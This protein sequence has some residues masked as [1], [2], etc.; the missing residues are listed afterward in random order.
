MR[1][2]VVT[3]IPGPRSRAL[4]RELRQHESRNVTFLDASWPVFWESA[5]GCQVWDAD[6]NRF[7]DFTSAFGVAG[8]G[9]RNP[10]VVAAMGEQ[11]NRLLHGMG[12]VH[13]TA[14][15]GELCRRL[16]ELTFER[17]QL[18]PGKVILS[19]SG[20]EAVESALK[21]ARLATGK[22][23]VLAF[24]NGYHGLGYGS[25]M[26]T[27]LS[28]F[29]G[30]F[31][32]QL[33]P[34]T[35]RI[36][37]G[38]TD[39]PDPGNIGVV[40]VEPIQGRGGKVLP[41]PGFLAAL[42]SWCDHHGA[43]LIFDEIYT[44]FHRTG[45]WFACEEDGV[46]PDLI[47]VGKAMSGG[48]PIS[49]CVGRAGIMDEWPESTGE[50]LHTST[51]LGNPVGCAMALKSL[52][53]LARPETLALVGKTSAVLANALAGLADLENVI[54]IRGRGVMWGVEL[55]RPGGPLLAELL[56][57]GLLFLA[58]GPR[59]NVLSFTPPFVMAEED[60]VFGVDRVRRLLTR[61]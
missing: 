61:S 47:C 15:K 57:E 22:P 35:T 44:G 38:S 59:G 45:S 20:F 54:A 8:L 19:N 53:I 1:P 5:E 11:A 2:E 25:L 34:V 37:Y 29:R 16:S 40:L 28:K 58:D 18:G 49:A 26:G 30:P 33:A 7:L 4:A 9:H 14:L 60:L 55:A 24:D 52:E 12:D 43:V 17:W 31:E 27:D 21:T 50:A 41:P 13:P 56:A 51:F 42:R 23:G 36:P 32:D 3:P 10:E 46:Y 39:L 6:G 48:F